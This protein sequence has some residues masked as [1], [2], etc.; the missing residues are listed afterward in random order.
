MARIFA[1]VLVS[2]VR[3]HR[4]LGPSPER[5]P[6]A[7]RFLAAC[8]SPGRDDRAEIVIASR[9]LRQAAIPCLP[10]FRDDDDET[11]L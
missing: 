6:I 11:R 2:A 9:F 5:E 10:D 1:R 7:W 3:H 8:R 4:D